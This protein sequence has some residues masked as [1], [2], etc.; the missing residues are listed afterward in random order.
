MTSGNAE[1]PQARIASALDRR[2]ELLGL[3]MEPLVHSDMPEG[4]SSMA[5]RAPA[6][7]QRSCLWGEVRLRC[8]SK[9]RGVCSGQQG[10]G[11]GRSDAI[12]FRP[13]QPT[14][15]VVFVDAGGSGAAWRSDWWIVW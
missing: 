11:R 12:Q 3:A 5:G 14:R 1:Y 8:P 9:A 13:V 10:L 15:P 7:R 6:M 4:R 2:A